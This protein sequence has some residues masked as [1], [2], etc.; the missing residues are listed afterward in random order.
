[1]IFFGCVLL[2]AQAGLITAH[3]DEQGRIILFTGGRG[4]RNVALR[5]MANGLLT[6][7]Q[8][9]AL[10]EEEFQRAKGEDEEES[11]SCCCAICL[12]EFEDKERVRVLPCR[13]KFHQVCLVPWLTEIHSS[14]PLCKFNVLEHLLSEH[15]ER[16]PSGSE[17][18][19]EVTPSTLWRPLR[20]FGGWTLISVH[21]QP[22]ETSGDDTDDDAEDNYPAQ[23]SEVEMETTRSVQASPQP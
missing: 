21:E 1:L 4:A 17:S 7:R 20:F 8:V 19:D 10:E 9:L 18:A 3:P 14:C 6:G 12:D 5:M 11:S 22:G 2:C 23:T 15:K 13:H 16:V